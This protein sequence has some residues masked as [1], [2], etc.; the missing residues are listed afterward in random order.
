MLIQ[1]PIELW[2]K[3]MLVLETYKLLVRRIMA[4]GNKC[5]C[6]MHSKIMQQMS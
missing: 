4:V 2:K 1:P 5:K 6:A 3:L